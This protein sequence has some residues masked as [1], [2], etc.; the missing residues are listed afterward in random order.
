MEMEQGLF[1]Q[2]STALTW[3]RFPSIA[4]RNN[5]SM[6]LLVHSSLC[7]EELF[8]GIKF[9]GMQLLDY[10]FKVYT[11]KEDIYYYME[12]LDYIRAYTFTSMIAN[13]TLFFKEVP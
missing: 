2:L 9:L 5:T 7:Q 3:C 11:F 12:L 13:D 6:D 4:I 10:T 8:L 1:N